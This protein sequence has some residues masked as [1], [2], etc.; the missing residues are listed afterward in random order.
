LDT[1]TQEMTERHL[2]PVMSGSVY[3]AILRI[4]PWL[5]AAA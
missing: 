2:M 4:S 3:V 1:V 5:C